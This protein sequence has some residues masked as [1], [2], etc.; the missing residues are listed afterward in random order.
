MTRRELLNIAKGRGITN[1]RALNKAEL[2]IVLDPRVS[3]SRVAATI[4]QAVARWMR[5]W[6][7]RG[8]RIAPRKWLMQNNEEE[9][10]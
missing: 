5:G 10:I 3:D 9:T 4:R 7:K 1:H 2:I 6:S 8:G